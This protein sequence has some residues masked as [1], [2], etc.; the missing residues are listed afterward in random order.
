MTSSAA[1]ICQVEGDTVRVDVPGGDGPLRV[2]VAGCPGPVVRGA[3]RAAVEAGRS[4]EIALPADLARVVV[5][6]PLSAWLDALDVAA[7]AALAHPG[8]VTFAVD[9]GD[10]GCDHVR[11][12]LAAVVPDPAATLGAVRD[13]L[14]ARRDQGGLD[15]AL[16]RLDDL[17]RRLVFRQLAAAWRGEARDPLGPVP[18][19][20]AMAAAVAHLGEAA[21]WRKAF[22]QFTY[23][24]A[25][26]L[27]LIPTWQC[28]LRCTYCWIPKQDGRVMTPDIVRRGL[29]L[30][31]STERDAVELQFFGGEALIEADLVR[32]AMEEATRRAAATGKRLGFVLSSNGWSLTPERLAWLRR[33]P[34]RMELSLDGD[35]ATQTRFRPAWEPRAAEGDSYA[36]SIATHARAILDSGIEQHVIMVV[37]PQGVDRL[38]HNFFHI[39]DLG[40]TRIQINNMLG[41][42][43]RAEQMQTWAQQLHQIGQELL[44][45]QGTPRAVELVN[46]EH[47]PEPMR[48]NGEVTVDF[49]GT[50]YGGNQFLHETEHKDRFALDHLDACT[51]IDRYWIDATDNGFLL[52]WA[53]RPTITRNNVEVGKVLASLCKHLRAQGLGRVPPS[54]VAD[55]T[56]AQAP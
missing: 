20:Q 26:R 15:G 49:D 47:R 19:P 32:Y 7:E 44:R 4:V 31:F 38:A 25:R 55:V 37:H 28:E 9:A 36:H 23:L 17:P 8:R 56:E 3:V 21:V 54:S 11:A 46:L 29:D 2:V 14:W 34:V 35:A 12:A 1:S 48:L 40:F 42:A 24:G 18:K 43:W 22:R 27:V 5:G 50:I 51:Q 45:R 10:P 52:D 33:F 41:V 16:R 30:L 39:A 53:Y 13:V 6:D